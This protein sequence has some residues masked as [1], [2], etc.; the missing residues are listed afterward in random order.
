MNIN[1]NSSGYYILIAS[2]TGVAAYIDFLT[3]L[4]QKTL[5]NLIRR[6][7]SSPSLHRINAIDANYDILNNIKVLFVG[8]FNNSNEFYLSTVI[9]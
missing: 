1:E 3:F 6:K 2:S 7:A 9:K 8:S 5:Y 4:L